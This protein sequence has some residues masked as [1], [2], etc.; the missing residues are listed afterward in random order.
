MIAHRVPATRHIV[1][2]GVSG[3]GKTTVAQGIAKV[4]GLAFA[5]ADD[6][7]TEASVAK[8]R[9]GIPLADEDR[10]PWLEA[11]AEWMGGRAA[12]GQST[13]IACSALRRVY[14]DVLRSG[15]PHH[16]DFVHLDGP[17]KVIRGRLSTREGH[18][19]PASL[20]DSQ[21]AT[22]EPLAPDES[23][24]VLDVRLP[25]ADLVEAAVHQL[26]LSQQSA[27]RGTGRP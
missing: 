9:A 7:H 12:T 16:V 18:Y 10:W 27:A 15:P 13:V 19:M 4:A 11:L 8:M 20:L 23:G 14:R 24:I 21:I 2:M 17:A 26:G 3:S 6:F 25:P 1:V 22:L 5:E